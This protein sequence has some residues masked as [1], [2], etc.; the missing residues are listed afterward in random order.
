MADVMDPKIGKKV[1]RRRYCKTVVKNTWS[2]PRLARERGVFRD[3]GLRH[4]TQR[5][6]RDLHDFPFS[7][8]DE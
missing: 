3:F 6:A 1:E 2:Q 7:Q 5:L 4:E 8:R